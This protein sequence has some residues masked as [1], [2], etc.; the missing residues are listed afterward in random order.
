[1]WNGMVLFGVIWFCKVIVWYCLICMVMVCSGM[2]EG[3]RCGMEWCCLPLVLYGLVLTKL[4]S[5]T[6]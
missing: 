5:V 2:A 4:G 1:M 6:I 3:V